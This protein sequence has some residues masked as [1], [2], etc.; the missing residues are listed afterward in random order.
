M[1]TRSELQDVDTGVRPTSVTAVAEVVETRVGTSPSR[2]RSAAIAVGAFY[3]AGDV[4]GG[5]S[6]LVG[7]KLFKE[8]GYLARIDAHQNQFAIGAL[9]ILAMGF[10]LAAI[11][12]VMYPIFRKTNEMVAIGYLVFRGALE[13]V[14]YLAQANNWLLMGDLSRDYVAAGSSDSPQYVSLGRQL[15]NQISITAH[16][17]EIVFSLGALLF[18]YL[19]Y[20]SRLIPQWL[21]IWGFVGGLFYLA[22]PLLSLFDVSAGWLQAPL[23]VQEITLAIWL[24]AKG[25]ESTTPKSSTLLSAD[26]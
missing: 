5:V 19:F 17:T 26:R 8:P 6:A 25:F 14:V 18:A 1:L 2:L 11:A 22:V 24:L 13:T 16:M 12:F 3:L 21:S 20:Q 4:V 15:K 10:F 9:C 7:T 23:G